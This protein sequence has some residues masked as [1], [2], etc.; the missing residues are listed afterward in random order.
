MTIITT[1]TPLD[2]DLVNL[3]TLGNQSD[4]SITW[5]A[6]GG[7]IITWVGNDNGGGGSGILLQR[8][9]A[10]GN[11]IGT[12]TIVNTY[13]ANN[14][15]APAI[16]GLAN[17]GYVVTW[18]SNLQDGSGTGI[19]IQ[20]F[21]AAGALVGS[22][23]RVNTTTSSAQNQPTITSFADSSYVVSWS[24]A[25]G[26]GS[27]YGVFGQRYNADGSK[28]GSE[29]LINTYASG[30]Q[31][32]SSITALDS[33]NFVVVWQ[34]ANQDGSGYG[35]YSQRYNSSG[36]AQGSETRVNT[37]TAS[38]QQFPAVAADAD[39][40]YVVAWQS[41]TS[42]DIYFQRYNSSGTAQGSET[43]ANP[44]ATSG[45]QSGVSAAYLNTGGFVLVWTSTVGDGSGSGIYAQRFTASGVADGSLVLINTY[46][47]GDQ[48]APSVTTLENGSYVV[49]WT[50][51]DQDGN[52]TGIYHKIVEANTAPQL[53]DD[54]ASLANGT[55]DNGY[56]VS[57]AS[58]LEGVTDGEG[59]DLTIA[60]VTGSNFTAVYNGSTGFDITPA[61]DFNGTLTL[62]YTV[63]DGHGGTLALTQSLVIDSVNDA[64]TNGGT[65]NVAVTEGGATVSVNALAGADDVD[66]GTDLYVV[67]TDELPAGVSYVGETQSIDFE[68]YT[69]GSV[70]GQHGWTDASPSSPANA[71]V[72]LA[73]NNVLRLAN[74]PTSGDFG[75]PYTPA[76]SIRAGETASGAEVNGIVF[77][78]SF[79]AVQ[80]AAD[81]S[82]IEIDLATAGSDRQNFMALESVAGGIRILQNTPN[83]DGS[84]ESNDFNFGTGNVTLAD[85]VDASTWHTLTVVATFNDGSNNDVLNYYLDGVLIGTGG[86]FE[87][88]N[89]GRTGIVDSI[90][91]R[92]GDPAGNPFPADGVGPN[93]QGFYIDNLGIQSFDTEA[94]FT[95]D[96][97]DPAYDY[98]AA[99]ETTVVTVNYGISDG[100]TTT[101]DAVTFT[102][103]GVNDAPVAQDTTATTE[104]DEAVTIDVASLISDVD[105]D[106]L[107]VTASVAEAEGTVTV[108]GTVITF[109]P[110]ANFNG[111]A[112]IT[113]WVSDGD[114]TDQG[115]V[116]V[117]V[118]AFDDAPVIGA[119]LDD[120]VAEGASITIDALSN[121]TDVDSGSL[122]VLPGTLPAGVT[123][124]GS[125]F[126]LDA[127]HAAYNGLGVGDTA[128]VVIN[129]Q[130]TDGVTP[131]TS[132]ITVTVT[133]TNDGPT[134][135]FYQGFEADSTGV[136]TGGSYGTLTRY[137]SPYGDI[138]AADGSA[139][140][141]LTE[142]GGSGAFTRFDGYRSNFVDGLTTGVKVY[143]DTAW[144]TG[145]GFDYSVAANG[146]DSIHQRDFIVHVAKDAT[147]GELLINADNGTNFAVRA[148]LD[149]LVD[150]AEITA[151]GWYTIEHVFS[152]AGGQL[153][154]EIRL[155]A[156]DGTVVFSKT[157][158]SPLDTI[159]AE[160][161]GNRYGWFTDITVAGGLAVDGLSL[162]DLAGAV[163]EDGTLS[164]TGIVPF[165]DVDL[166]DEHTIAVSGDMGNLGTLT[167]EIT[168]DSTGTGKGIVTWS[169]SVDNAAVQHLAAGEILEETYTLTLDDGNGATATQDVTIVI[170]GT[171]DGPELTGA[172]TVLTEG[173]EDTAYLVTDAELLAGFSDVDATDTL[174]IEDLV[175]S[176]GA[177]VTP[178]VGG[179][180]IS[181]PANYNGL[182]TLSYN[183]VDGNGGSI[184]G[185]LTYNLAPVNDA[186][187]AQDTTATTD[188][189]E[190]VT[191]D[192]AS[193]I[194]DIDSG[195]L[196]VT[197]TVPEAQGTV[198][199]DGT[200]ITFT[201]A[202]NF[203]GEA[204]ISYTVSDGELTDTATVTVTVDP[205]NDA[206]TNGGTTDVAATEGGATVSVNALAG[207]DD[208]DEG[209]DL[210]VVLTD[211]LPAGVSYV[212]ETQSFD[213][214]DYTAGSV[215]GQH[216]WTDASPSSPANAIVDLAGNNVL[217]LANDPT[218][219]D[220]GGPYTPALSIRAGETASGAEVNG[221][222]FSFSFMAVQ[223]TADG[224]RIEIDLAT[225][226][227]DRQSFMA[228]ESM[229]G[230]IRI[231]QN[232]AN[233]D[234]S[235]ESNDFNFG[236]GNVTLAD[237]VDASTW[238]TLTVV[239]TFNDG[240]NND[241]LNYYLDGVLIGTGGSFED[242]NGGRTGIVDSIL[243]RAGDPA[244]NP[245]PAD[246]VG[247]NRQ[248]FYID[249]LGIQ[250]FDTEASFTFDPT[251]PAYDYLAAG[252]TT[253]VTVN[254]GISDGTTTT[255]DAVTF[256]VTG[257]NDGPTI[258]GTPDDSGSVTEDGTLTATG[259]V[260][261]ADVDLSDSHTVTVSGTGLGSLTAEVTEAAN[262]ATGS[263]NWSFS[264]DN[265]AV[266]YLAEGETLQQTYTLTLNDGKGGTATQDVTITITGTNDGPVASAITGVE[267]TEETAVVIDVADHVSDVDDDTL[268]VTAAT[269]PQGTIT[270]IS[271][272]QFTFTPAANFYG[273]ATITYTIS[274]G[275]LTSQNTITVDV[276]N[277]Y[278]I[279][280]L[281]GPAAE[282]A[283]GL[284]DTGYEL[285]LADLVQNLANPD[286]AELTIGNFYSAEGTVTDN[287]DGTFHFSPIA[288]YFGSVTINYE[289]D[290]GTDQVLNYV[291]FELLNKNDAPTAPETPAS[292]GSA[293][294][295][296]SFTGTDA[297]L[298][299][300][301]NDIDFDLDPGLPALTVTSISSSV[302][303]VTR[304]GNDFT[305][306]FSGAAD[307][308]NGEVT[309][310]YVVSD[311]T[312][313]VESTR[314]LTVTPTPDAPEMADPADLP[315]TA[316]DTAITVTTASLLSGIT[317]PDGDTE[318]TIASIS[319][320]HGQIVA[321]GDDYSYT[322]DP[323]FFGT[324]TITYT[325]SDGVS[326][327]APLQNSFE[328]TPVNDAPAG[329]AATVT[330]VSEDVAKVLT[331]AELLAGVTDIDSAS[332]SFSITAISATGGTIVD[333]GNDTYTF[334]STANYNGA[335]S[336]SYTVSDG[337]DSSNYTSNF[338]VA[339]VNDAPGGTAATVT[340]DEDVAKLLTKADLLA[341]VTDIDN[342]FAQ[343][344]ITAI[345]ATG[346]T[347]VDN[348]ND[349]YT[350]L[351]DANYHGA[352]SITYTVFDGEAST[353]YTSNFTVASVIDL[354][355]S[356]TT[357][358]LGAT[359]EDLLLTGTGNI[360]GTG[361]SLDNKLTGNS[362]D[363]KLDGA[364]GQDTLYGMG[365]DDIYIIDNSEDVASEESTPGIDDG[366]F[367]TVRTSVSYTLGNFIEAINLNGTGN[368]SAFGNAGSNFLTGNAGNNLLDGGQGA[369]IMAGG[370][371][372]DTFI[373]DTL[374][375][376]ATETAG[377]GTDL[378]E[379]SVTFT[380][381]TEVENLTLT[382]TDN[383]NGTGNSLANILTGNS[384]INILAGGLGNDSYYVQNT[385]DN[386][387][388]ATNA[389]TDI[390]FATATYSL[391]GRQ[392]ENLTLLGISNLNATGNSLG[393][394][395]IGN[396]G[397]NILDGGAGHDRLD[398]GLGTD[399]NIGGTGNDTYIIDN[400]SDVITELAGGGAD[401]AESTVS[402]TLSSDVEN[403]TLVSTGTNAL[404]GTG[405]AIN[406]T[407][408]GSRGG[409]QLSGLGGFDLLIG[410]AGNDLLDGGTGADTM[411]GGADSDTY[412]VDN[413]D[414][415][416]SEETVL[417]VNDTGNDLVVASVSYTLGNF[418]ERLTLS[419]AGNIDGTGN[420]QNNTIAGNSGNNVLVGAG[421]ADT[422]SGDAG[423][424]R[425]IGGT[426][427]DNMTGG[428][429]ADTFV[430]ARSGGGIDQVTDFQAGLDRLAFTA[431]DFGFTAGHTLTDAQ[432]NL[433]A[434]VGTTGQFVYNT[435]TNTL[436]WD[437]NG[438]GS[439]GVTTLATFGNAPS[440]TKADFI[441]E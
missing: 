19:Y 138:E 123:F 64:P 348:G 164:S 370:Q 191:I 296:G 165:G 106:T 256:T 310:T 105:S 276:A 434:A 42:A 323:D 192:V 23:S 142:A 102:V 366:G 76:L 393:N 311:G 249:N 189:D 318:F 346:G 103:T 75:G 389:G 396:V 362:G 242:Y 4:P 126:T 263:I 381:G 239:A 291:T 167:A 91:F 182:I 129:Y 301:W 247:P 150:S 113:Y 250:T 244:G 55:E 47:T 277:S 89:G 416:V 419:G 391:A 44:G 8:Y 132:S 329:D 372:N 10:E 214:E 316:E 320:N 363:N 380:L 322:P 286:N 401:L 270:S 73:G 203:N 358:T 16:T 34:S 104:E 402:Y 85:G 20:Q 232:T 154:V 398:G 371:G 74:D 378:V 48:T 246:G 321:D 312:T 24:S 69:A 441:F 306:D 206:P 248:G 153:A 353:Q 315:A 100:T 275:S 143:L 14:Q 22:E 261:F 282:L 130:V 215:V 13:L 187:V 149:T 367:D 373:V 390:V 79:M 136:I 3:T 144:A 351:S 225:A 319:V 18:V 204:S 124:A 281:T 328:V 427:N 45:V 83:A 428:A 357:T 304:D 140:A 53:T 38:N 29:F 425:I 284:E 222:V 84:W 297:D 81:G 347:I 360:D 343:L 171:N 349:T 265:A 71:I 92:A 333:N 49:T 300:G 407:L 51:A 68:D 178:T 151:T 59:H 7:Y 25:S 383:I 338:T 326:T 17:G 413:A 382:G 292:L 212:G 397:N 175:A 156:E 405:N 369:D 193:L 345:S 337:E 184:A 61:D 279:P 39:G 340:A 394:I 168:T 331:K 272:T 303:T 77:S 122:T 207:A 162:G 181:H 307:D 50:S 245:F 87:D 111:A 160:V 433:N 82:R 409:N 186:P 63:A 384:G 88:Y 440:L 341:D 354:V 379:A 33:G 52:G 115:T 101:D 264:V 107:T 172:Q 188:E 78:F 313:T 1:F 135:G 195:S 5:L 72:D 209:T 399:T 289:I 236:T 196:T 90:L 2:E 219:G 365:G 361:N 404:N 163:T 421:G 145:Q 118:N 198:S 403:L 208:V 93:R 221:I 406:N 231:L 226:G 108:D 387:S 435:A 200:V 217:R 375:E 114:L 412:M 40:N 147:T 170:N 429:D 32:A 238:H 314:T 148:D 95:F 70:V 229:D 355:T 183:V 437:S 344:S 418:V 57:I 330:G 334:T 342:S 31:S 110:A 386:V 432:F 58:L 230:G 374:G 243:F 120:T 271:G 274:D 125:S 267:A 213:F 423:T 166:T 169:F 97:T 356:S 35:I 46:T 194:S 15:T 179:Y 410:G 60:A 317:D 422:I 388:E 197:A 176:D 211:E 308:F 294:E 155:V 273:E 67:L 392:V 41:P 233:A 139:F 287:G 137:T 99:G 109:T 141:V 295:A 325:V 293:A 285:A 431:I 134:L 359:D 364:T 298:L 159:P 218:S 283:D 420:S 290:N 260:D 224:S 80:G 157:L 259:S 258:T 436:V 9:D 262:S 133:G 86:S 146:S 21:D 228:L 220:F 30:D 368:I 299:A 98:L 128:D 174:S 352:A 190:A 257:T 11:A 305:I 335:A 210:Y 414:D 26:D 417:G 253:V 65:T 395:L 302:G 66:E 202:S 216:G 36:V 268:F 327:S 223:G 96:P 158:S 112:S 119:S 280:Y 376:F 254:Y 252:E 180:S 199:V 266:Q 161:G 241:V 237:G 62:N 255:D 127:T 227:S 205:V 27:S 116:S 240:S 12:E 288:D 336:I 177:I 173:F 269:S 131:V 430:F 339:A 278:D 415:I 201:P 309:I 152:D 54:Q 411:Y 332:S 350:F 251:D 94:S 426:G 439:G 121:V 400:T 377:G 43:I 235:W 438:T 37:T 185:T 408:T 56:F 385:S 324:V 6:D 234:G 117:T 424:D 28:A